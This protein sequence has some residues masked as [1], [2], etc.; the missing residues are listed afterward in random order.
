MITLFAYIFTGATSLVVLF[1]IALIL[2]APW[3]AAAMGGKFPHKFP[4]WMRGVSVVN[5]VLLV[6]LNVIVLSRANIMMDELYSFSAVAI[7]FVVAFY[8][9]G[10]ILNTITP[11]KIEKIW[12]PVAFT[13]MV[14][15]GRAHV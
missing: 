7:W 9:L 6:F 8:L 13:H 5:I 12:A 3:G 4:A 14:K 15:I 1:Y 10:T 2:G 11:S